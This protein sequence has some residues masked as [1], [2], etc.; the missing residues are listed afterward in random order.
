MN[1]KRCLRA[2]AG[3]FSVAAMMPGIGHA[4][5]AS[6]T[7]SATLQDGMVVSCNNLSF[8]T[9]IRPANYA[10]GGSVN[11]Q[12]NGSVSLSPG[13]AHL[14]DAQAGECTV[15]GETGS[16]ATAVLSSGAATWNA[17]A[18]ALEGV[19]LDGGAGTNALVANLFLSKISGIGNET[20]KISGPVILNSAADSPAGTYTSAPVTITVTD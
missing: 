2:L 14:N 11:V 20:L 9:I 15:S 7:A 10:G 19:A 13:L 1:K 17:N 16:D 8:G 6:F 5:D 12:Q 3:A 4:A 18:W